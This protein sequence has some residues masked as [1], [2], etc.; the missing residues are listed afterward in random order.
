MSLQQLQ[1]GGKK[2]GKPTETYQNFVNKA[3]A[4]VECRIK[5]LGYPVENIKEAYESM[6]DE[7]LRNEADLTTLLRMR[8]ANDI[9]NMLGN[10]FKDQ[11]VAK[12]I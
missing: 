8:G 7:E 1:P 9:K 6:V 10:F 3:I 11:L 4:K 12:T 2:P 5:V